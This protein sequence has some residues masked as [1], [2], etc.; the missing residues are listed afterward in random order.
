[1]EFTSDG[2]LVGAN[3]D[4]METEFSILKNEVRRN[5][6][7]LSPIKAFSTSGT[8]VMTLA[9]VERIFSFYADIYHQK[10]LWGG[11]KRDF[12]TTLQWSNEKSAEENERSE[13]E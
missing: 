11:L 8:E 4:T 13:E 12:L 5:L 7:N 3:F 10:V 2:L 1:M 9:G 6:K